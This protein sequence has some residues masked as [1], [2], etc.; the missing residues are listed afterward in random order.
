MCQTILEEMCT[1]WVMSIE[2]QGNQGSTNP[3]TICVLPYIAFCVQCLL[4]YQD[5]AKFIMILMIPEP[6]SAHTYLHATWSTVSDP[7]HTFSFTMQSHYQKLTFI[8]NRLKLGK[9]MHLYFWDTVPEYL[10]NSLCF[11]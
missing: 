5:L 9:S 3:D 2:R 4:L 8:F 6:C 11:L 10:M 1:G 7:F